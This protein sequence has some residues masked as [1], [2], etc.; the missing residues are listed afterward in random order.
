MNDKKINTIYIIILGILLAAILTHTYAHHGHLILDSGREAY[1]PTQVLAGKILYKDILNIYGPFAYM[2]N[3]LLY[4]LFGLNLNVLYSAGISCTFIIIS[5]IYLISRKFLDKFLSFSIAFFTLITG[6]ASTYLSNFIFPYSYAVLY[7]LTAFLASM[8]C[9]FNYQTSK[10]NKNLYL[11]CFFAGIAAAS[12]Y[13]FVLP[14]LVIIYAMFKTKPLNLKEIFLAIISF[15]IIPLSLFSILFIQ[16]LEVSDLIKTFDIIIKM[17]NSET[18]KYF[19]NTQNIYFNPHLFKYEIASFL[20]MIFPLPFFIYGFMTKN[21]LVSTILIV[22]STVLIAKF[23]N[24]LSLAILPVL[25]VL[26]GILN[27]K[28]LKSDI[29]LQL[30]VISAFLFSL[31]I[32]WGLIIAN[33]G[34]FFAGY[35]LLAFVVLGFKTFDKIA[36]KID[37]IIIGIYIILIAITI[38]YV[39]TKESKDYSLSTDYG[40]IY[41]DGYLHYASVDLIKYII[42]NTQKTDK[43]VIFPEGAM[44]NF[45]TQRPSDNYYTSLIPL[46][47]EVFGENNII[48]HFRETK[49]EYIIFNNLNTHDYYFKYI[50][51]D[52]GLA[53]CSFVH[54]NYTQEKVIDKG[55]RYLIYKKN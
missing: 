52:Y 6:V 1:Y 55:F 24:P 41:T 23:I 53:F 10:G 33:Y 28:K 13:E 27:I 35:L 5:L 3:A 16:G 19:Y 2:F 54:N 25:I 48:R 36:L 8:F 12:K 39:N 34:T 44:I 50:C 51:Q 38:G 31:K 4:K 46:Y 47:I 18:L 37:T 32:F 9:L 20:M 30:L 49:P 22:L 40:K 17:T 43:V 29:M 14:L 26:M 15:L 21:K 7:G 42:K 11:A 45:L